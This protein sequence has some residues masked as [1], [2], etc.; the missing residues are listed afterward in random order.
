MKI[1][2]IAGFAV[3]T[4]DPAA[5]AECYLKR[6]GLPLEARG[7]YLSVDGFAGSRHFGVWPL[8][9]AAE[10]CFGT[11]HWPQDVPVPTS[12][13][14]FE[15]QDVAALQAAVDEMTAAGQS[16]VHGPREEPWGQTLAR[17]L[18]PENVLVGLSYA[19][20]LHE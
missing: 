19:P 2:C 5:S 8:A 17:F 20:W 11:Q 15:L 4:D 14:E 13:I 3:I 1:E 6:L 16:F 7:D 12:T 10:S 18:S 9:M